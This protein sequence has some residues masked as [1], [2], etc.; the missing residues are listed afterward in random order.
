MI[1]STRVLLAR[2]DFAQKHVERARATLEAVLDR[3]GSDMSAHELLEVYALR[4]QVSASLQ[5]YAQAY[6]DLSTYVERYRTANDAERGRQITALS[7]QLESDRVVERNAALQQ[8]LALSNERSRVQAMQ[9]RWT[10]IATF[11]GASIIGLLSYLLITNR[12]YRRL[13]VRQAN[14]DALTGLPNRRC[15]TERLAGHLHEAAASGQPLTI[16]LLDFDHFKQINDRYGH[17]CGDFVLREFAR[18]SR[19]VLRADDT[20]GRWGGEEFLLILPNCRLDDAYRGVERLRK[21]VVDMRLPGAPSD[22]RVSVSAGLATKISA[23]ISPEELVASADAA[24]YDAKSGGRDLSRIADASLP[25]ASTGLRRTL[26][27]VPQ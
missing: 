5:D 21:L 26:R 20:L 22:T 24:L 17:A 10:R 15:T 19:T 18:L 27:S 12:R 2:V 7:A 14:Q 23:R 9:L 3:G 16:A 8:E 4:A 25:A 13:L 6:R 11:V 1:K